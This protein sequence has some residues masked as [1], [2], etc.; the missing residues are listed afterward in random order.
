MI[1]DNGFCI[2]SNGNYL[3][4]CYKYDGSDCAADCSGFSWCIGYFYDTTTNKYCGL[5]PS[6]LYF[7][8]CPS[9]Y[10]EEHNNN[11]AETS[12]DVAAYPRPGY[13]CYSKIPGIIKL[14]LFDP[15]SYVY[16]NTRYSLHLN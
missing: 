10:T 6:G 13:S 14:I 9:G 16:H 11:P 12:D 3:H 1:T 8:T 5:I 15:C 4:L 2:H 7:S